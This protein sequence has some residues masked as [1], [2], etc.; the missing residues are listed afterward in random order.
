MQVSEDGINLTKSFESLKL[1]SYPDSEGV[2]TVGWGTTHINGVPVTLGMTITQDEAEEYLRADYKKFENSINS[3]VKVELSQQ[4]FDAVADF[5][6]NE[7]P[8]HFASST[9]L[10]L[11]NESDF[12]NAKNEFI[13]WDKAGGHVLSGLLRRR[14][15]EADLF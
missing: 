9:L 3:L 4:Q 14:Q 11:I 5:V 8:T 12:E 15:A 6:Y 10:K 2:P 7:G 1:H 13:K